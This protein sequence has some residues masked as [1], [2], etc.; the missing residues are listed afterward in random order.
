MDWR[1]V[2]HFLLFMDLLIRLEDLLVAS[3]LFECDVFK[4][5]IWTKRDMPQPLL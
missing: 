5:H 1:Q 2:S 4:S 3:H